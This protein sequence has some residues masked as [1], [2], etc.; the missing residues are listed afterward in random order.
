VA[1]A[2]AAAVKLRRFLSK[3]GLRVKPPVRFSFLFKFNKLQIACPIALLPVM[4]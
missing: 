1:S 2:S 3:R 4:E